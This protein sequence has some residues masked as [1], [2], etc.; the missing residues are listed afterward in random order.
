MKQQKT[1]KER[2]IKYL[3]S[4]KKITAEQA[5]NKFGTK[6]LRAAIGDLKEDGY[7]IERVKVSKNSKTSAYVMR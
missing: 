3:S 5:F 1:Q 7:E 4:G 6:N 2:L